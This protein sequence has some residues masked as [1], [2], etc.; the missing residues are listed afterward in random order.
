MR[1]VFRFLAAAILAGGL[2]LAAADPAA[3]QGQKLADYLDALNQQG[4]KIIYTSDLVDDDLKLAEEPD[5]ERPEEGLAD[6]LR[7]FGLTAIGG[8]SGSLL[9]VGIHDRREQE[10]VVAMQPDQIPIP[11]LVVTS[12][13]H[14]LDYSHPG[15]HT[16]LDQE[17]ATRIP[18]TAGEA[19]RITNRL[20]GT[21]SGGVSSRNH[22]RGGEVNEV[23]F[24]FDGLR[25]YEP[26]H[27]KDFQSIATIVNS[28]AIAGMDFF[29]GA[30]PARYGDRMSGVMNIEM[31]KPDKPVQT[32]LA[33]SFFNTS[34]LSLGTFG[35]AEQGDWLVSGRRSNLDLIIDVVRPEFGNPDYQ[36]YLA[37]FGW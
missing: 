32:E 35:S 16:Y 19:V 36:D 14:R 11:E 18:T 8:P 2:Q 26:Y 33:L 37:H 7:P 27:L 23:L 1:F 29:T 12:S 20:P 31:R 17:L 25:L 24:L 28:N 3:W 30:Y 13:L 6:V 15:T 21:A 5:A 34:A 4:L 9:V 10:P 22:I